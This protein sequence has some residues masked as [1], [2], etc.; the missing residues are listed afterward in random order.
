MQNF[1]LYNATANATTADTTT[2][3]VVVQQLF[4]YILY[5]WAKMLQPNPDNQSNIWHLKLETL[6]P[7]LKQT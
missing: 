6:H 1:K 5:R 2:D 3:A 4:L 7:I